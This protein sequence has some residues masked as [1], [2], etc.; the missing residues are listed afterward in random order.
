MSAVDRSQLVE[1]AQVRITLSG[2]ITSATH[3]D[4]D[5]VLLVETGVGQA[6][7][8]LFASEI[9]RVDVAIEPARADQGSA[10]GWLVLLAPLL[11]IAGAAAVVLV[12]VVL[13]LLSGIGPTRSEVCEQRPTLCTTPTPSP[14]PQP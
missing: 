13:V 5:V 3:L 11:A 4:D 1:G 10:A 9:E 6:P 7:V 2:R 12:A 8:S 14:E